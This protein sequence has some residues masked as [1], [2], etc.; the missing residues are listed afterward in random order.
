M[1]H[2]VEVDLE[3]SA[4]VTDESVSDERKFTSSVLDTKQRKSGSIELS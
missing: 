4:E 2:G 3:L 1:L